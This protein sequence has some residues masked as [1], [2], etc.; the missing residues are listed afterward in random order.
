MGSAREHK[1]GSVNDHRQPLFN[2]QELADLNPETRQSKTFATYAKLVEKYTLRKLSYES[3]ILNAFSGLF[4]VLNEYFQSDIISGLPASVLDL[5]LLWAP[6]ARLP[7][8]GCKLLTMENF[9]L[10]QADRNFPSCSWAGWTGPV[11]YRLFAETMSAE[12]PLPTP[13]IKSSTVRANGKLQTI[14]ARMSGKEKLPSLRSGT[15]D[16]ATTSHP[17]DAPPPPPSPSASLASNMLQFFAPCVPLVVFSI[18]PQREYLSRQEHIHSI[19]SQALRHILDPRGKRCGPCWEQAGYVYVGRDM[20]ADAESRMQLVGISQHGDTFH[21][22]RGPSRVEG[23]IRVFDEAEYPSVAKGSGL[24]NVL[25]IDLDMG[26]EYAERI[27]VAW[28]HVKAW[29]EA[30]PRMRLVQLT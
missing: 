10:G 14:P 21:P 5:A 17:T 8:R 15:P 12:E 3:D 11:E 29:E 4:A 18:P 7:R 13:L 9:D 27:T 25:A 24:V 19:G 6:A 1:V 22:R 16:T 20:S 23:E 2:L 30:G 28:I 26:H